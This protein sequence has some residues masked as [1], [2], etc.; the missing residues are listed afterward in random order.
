M[1]YC[2]SS[3]PQNYR[4]ASRYRPPIPL[5][6]RGIAIIVN[7]L[8]SVLSSPVRRNRN[9]TKSLEKVWDVRVQILCSRPNHQYRMGGTGDFV[10]T[11]PR[12]NASMMQ[13][14]LRC[15]FVPC[16][17]RHTLLS[18]F[19]S[20]S[21]TAHRRAQGPSPTLTISVLQISKDN[22]T[23]EQACLSFTTARAWRCRQPIQHSAHW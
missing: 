4:R 12:V 7:M 22:Q 6:P 1:S 3:C 5:V 23:P 9:T 20:R 15:F 13:E 14:V 10:P 16:R 11:Y 19:C 18:R 8:L 21:R 2:T 17:C